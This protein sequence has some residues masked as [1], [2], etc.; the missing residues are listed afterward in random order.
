M[1]MGDSDYI[2]VC[3]TLVFQPLLL[4]LHTAHYAHITAPQCFSDSLIPDIPQLLLVTYPREFLMPGQYKEL[5]QDTKYIVTVMHNRDHYAITIDA[6]KVV[7]KDGIWHP[8]M[9]WIDHIS[10][11]KRC[12][13][14]GLEDM[15]QFI[16][17]AATLEVHGSMRTC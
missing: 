14:I 15:F 16:A 2:R 13:L 11:L 7:V 5:S 4:L 1:V 3:R 9:K 6:K 10:A 12:M 8:L 17:D